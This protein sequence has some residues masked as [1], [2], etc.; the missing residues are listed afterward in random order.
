[1]LG[2]NMGW[3]QIQIF[4]HKLQLHEVTAIYVEKSES[5]TA[6]IA[7]WEGG[8]GWEGLYFVLQV[9]NHRFEVLYMY[10]AILLV[11]FD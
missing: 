7:F 5:D 9:S 6:K 2:K 10:I 4:L 3:Y 1:M 8:I 11:G